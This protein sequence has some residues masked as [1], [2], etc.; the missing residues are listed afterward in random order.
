MA[1]QLET[2]TY[3]HG[4]SLNEL[5]SKSEKL[6]NAKNDDVDT[7]Y[8]V[9]D[10]IHE[11]AIIFM[12]HAIKLDNKKNISHNQHDKANKNGD[13]HVAGLCFDKFVEFCSQRDKYLEKLCVLLEQTKKLNE[14]CSAIDTLHRISL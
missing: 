13:E 9:I 7:L 14:R 11:H 8:D 12:K 5:L 1:N 6:L 2:D 3:M 4:V 10:E